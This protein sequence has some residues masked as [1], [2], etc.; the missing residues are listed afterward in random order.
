LQN[1]ASGFIARRP[2]MSRPVDSTWRSVAF[3]TTTSTDWTSFSNTSHPS[4]VVISAS[5]E[6]L[7]R[8]CERPKITVF[9]AS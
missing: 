4:S 8:I 1:T 3:Q 2:S 6:R 7:P 5:I 9:Q